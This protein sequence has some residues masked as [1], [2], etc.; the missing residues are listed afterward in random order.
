[1][2]TNPTNP[3][4]QAVLADAFYLL[5]A[6][7]GP[8]V[9]KQARHHLGKPSDWQFV[10]EHSR[11]RDKPVADWGVDGLIKLMRTMWDSLFGP[12]LGVREFCIVDLLRY[13]NM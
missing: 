4:N 11:F 7:L 5:T 6:E 1:M 12:A 2:A 10:Y 3:T 13:R 8:F 9:E